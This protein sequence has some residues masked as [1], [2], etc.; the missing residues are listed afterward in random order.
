MLDLKKLLTKILTAI[1]FYSDKEYSINGSFRVRRTWNA[2][3]VTYRGSAKA[4][5]HSSYNLITTLGTNERPASN[6]YFPAYDNET[7]DVTKVPLM[8]YI[9]TSGEVYIWVYST[10]GTNVAPCFNVT[11][12]KSGGDTA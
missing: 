1:G 3:N 10:S 4:Y 9:N 5:T 2:V 7:N 8:G 12:L 6:V 11:F